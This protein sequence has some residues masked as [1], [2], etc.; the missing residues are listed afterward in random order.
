[1]NRRIFVGVA[2][3]GILALA[4]VGFQQ[5]GEAPTAH[6]KQGSA[7]LAQPPAPESHP[8]RVEPRSPPAAGPVRTASVAVVSAPP[9]LDERLIMNTLRELGDSAPQYSLEMARAGNARFPDS[10][11]AAE[12]AWYVCKSLVNLENFYDARDEARL[13]VA[14]YPGTPWAS[15]VERHLLVNPLDLPGDPAP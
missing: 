5:L 14:K 3:V 4:W 1:M 6:S 11:D 12:R 8:S 10:P 9:P 7:P 13:M 2:A 15:D